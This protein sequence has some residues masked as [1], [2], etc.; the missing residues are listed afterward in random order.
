MGSRG[1]HC[2]TRLPELILGTITNSK[3]SGDLAGCPILEGSDTPTARAL[4]QVSQRSVLPRSVASY[5]A[6]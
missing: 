5:P 1:R 4:T 6:A 2:K 3:R